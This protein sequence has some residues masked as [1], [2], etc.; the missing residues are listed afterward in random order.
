MMSLITLQVVALVIGRWLLGFV[1]SKHDLE[2]LDDPIPDSLYCRP[3]QTKQSGKVLTELEIKGSLQ[4]SLSNS[5]H[6]YQDNVQEDGFQED[7]VVI[8]E[9][10]GM[11]GN[12]TSDSGGVVGSMVQQQPEASFNLTHEVDQC[13][14][15]RNMVKNLD[16]PLPSPQSKTIIG[17][18]AR[19]RV[20]TEDLWAHDDVDYRTLD[21]LEECDT[22]LESGLISATWEIGG[23]EA[24]E[25]L[26]SSKG[27]ST[28][29]TSSP[30]FSNSSQGNSRLW[31]YKVEDADYDQEMADNAPGSSTKPVLLH[32]KT[33]P[34]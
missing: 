29:R 30:A 20:G 1:F 8:C 2:L 24:N 7:G 26:D 34:V 33:T 31:T 16:A 27:A 4:D 13:D 11:N 28:L 21:T 9:P 18:V 22:D 23:D 25:C 6:L 32:Y 5:G 10:L 19:V 3:C 14:L 12:Y 17:D 15:W